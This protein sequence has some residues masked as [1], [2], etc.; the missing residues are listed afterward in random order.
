LTF[1]PIYAGQKVATGNIPIDHAC[2]T[3]SGEA[4]FA[5]NKDLHSIIIR[6]YEEAESRHGSIKL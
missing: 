6:L 4:S 5:T 2:S 3:L 1:F